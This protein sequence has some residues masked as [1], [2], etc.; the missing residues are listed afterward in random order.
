V[1]LL[2]CGVR[3][4]TP[5]PGRQFCRYGGNTSCIGVAADGE[6]PRLV[7]D[8]GTGLRRLSEELGGAP[9]RGTLLLGH[10]HWD[11]THGLPFFPA[12]DHPDAEVRL[13]LPAQEG[14]AHAVLSR[15][16]SPPH[17]PIQP[18]QLRG[19]WQFGGLESGEHAI[20][21]FTVLALDIPHKGGR[22][23]GF[24]VS[25]GASSF[26]YLS[27][28]GPIAL[29]PGPEGL[30]EYHDAVMQLC[31]GADLLLHDSQY[32]AEEF[33]RYREFGHSAI[34]YTVGLAERAG[35][36]RLMLFHHDPLRRDDELDALLALHRRR[37]PA[38]DAAAEG[39]VIELPLRAGVG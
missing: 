30:G 27:D 37:F 38:L 1:R 34:E 8:A 5:A 31:S 6:A 24:R 21:G 11:H 19:R 9:F 29:G 22:T 12:G 20:E 25:D 3:G 2:I 36:G 23:F 4:S 15:A 28:H 13:L 14:E 7:L 39:T 32:T 35:V 16:M 33:P 26:A 10:L 18:N 17:F